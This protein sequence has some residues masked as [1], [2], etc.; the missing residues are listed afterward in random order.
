MQAYMYTSA[1]LSISCRDININ[2]YHSQGT[3]S[4]AAT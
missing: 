2:P 1:S 3:M 4:A